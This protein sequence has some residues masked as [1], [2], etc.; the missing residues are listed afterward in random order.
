MSKQVNQAL[1][2]GAFRLPIEASYAEALRR[3]DGRKF[4][5]FSFEEMPR[6]HKQ[7]LEMVRSLDDP[8]VN[9]SPELRAAILARPRL[10]ALAAASRGYDLLNAK[11][12]KATRKVA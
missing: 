10:I 6:A 1:K 8:G 5:Q 7:A 2:T 11:K 4:A 12:A 3:D 9:P